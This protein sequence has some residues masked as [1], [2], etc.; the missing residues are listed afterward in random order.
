MLRLPVGLQRRPEVAAL[1]VDLGE[2]LERPPASPRAVN[3]DVPPALDAI[4]TKCLAKDPADRYADG[5]E[6]AAALRAAA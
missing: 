3:A 6:L 5:A 2:A 1:L 4:V